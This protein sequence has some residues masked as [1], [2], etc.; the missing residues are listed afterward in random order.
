MKL[1]IVNSRF[2][3]R[4]GGG[5][6]YILELMHYFSS[7][8]WEVHLLTSDVG[9]KKEKWE[10]CSIHY[11]SGF[12]DNDGNT[13]TAIPQFRRVLD[14]IKPDL[15]HVHNIM[16]YFL[17]SSITSVGEFPVV[18][19][20][21][22]TPDVPR[23]LFG[24]FK[25]FEAEEAFCRQLLTNKRY[26]ALLFGSQYYLDAYAASVPEIRQQ[27]T[28][29]AHYFPPRLSVGTGQIKRMPT[30]TINLLFPS[31]ILPRKGIEDCLQALALLSSQYVLHLPAMASNELGGY[32]DTV[33]ELINDLGLEDR[34]I[35][36]HDITTPDKMREYYEK[37]DMVIIPSHY[38]GFGIVAVEAL[39]WALPVV[40][41]GVGGLGE[42]IKDGVN[43][44]Y[45]RPHEPESLATAIEKVVGDDDMREKLV[46]EGLRIVDSQ[47][48]Y[49]RH[50]KQ[51]EEIYREVYR[52]NA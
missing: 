33:A 9:Y 40:T 19:T 17:F 32:N 2:L 27:G 7:L 18:L 28:E 29:V 26:Q 49:E 52:A 4:I 30:D 46:Q 11:I 1:L 44:I 31:R 34:V 38:E 5:E 22:N 35:R 8:G 24:S 6:T 20:V 23:R 39:S 36:P 50:M 47:F 3:P 13:R 42:I 41:T 37:A 43:G 51:V 16:P 45:S 10:N 12:D 48:S 14:R 21:H 25:D 15:V